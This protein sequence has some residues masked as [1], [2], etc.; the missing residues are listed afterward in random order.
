MGCNLINIIFPR[1]QGKLY[2]SC[3][4]FPSKNNITY[5]NRN[6]YMRGSF[7][8]CIT[9][10]FTHEH[11]RFQILL[12][13]YIQFRFLSAFLSWLVCSMTKIFCWSVNMLI[14][15][16]YFSDLSGCILVWTLSSGEKL[17]AKGMWSTLWMPELHFKVS[18]ST[19]DITSPVLRHTQV[20][21]QR[22]AFMCAYAMN[23][24]TL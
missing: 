7:S 18:V 17:T 22:L 10:I 8:Y 14:K 20:A 9:H 24:C 13:L 2:E 21:R 16:F 5:I 12:P 6:P 1:S 3:T 23:D 11:N 4:I 15:N 19:V